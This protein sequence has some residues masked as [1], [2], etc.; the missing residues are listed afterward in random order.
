MRGSDMPLTS[1][2][3][4]IPYKVRIVSCAGRRRTLLTGDLGRSFPKSFPSTPSTHVALEACTIR[5]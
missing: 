1:S 3:Y 5:I 4:G 2:Y